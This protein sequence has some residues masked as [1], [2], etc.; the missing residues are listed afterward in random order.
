MRP[1]MSTV[2]GSSIALWS[3]N[4]MYWKIIFVLSLSKLAQPPFLHCIAKIQSR[5][6]CETSIWL[7]SRGMAHAVER[8]QYLRRI[9]HI[10]VKL[11]VKLE[12]PSAGLDIGKTHRP[13]ALVAD[14]LRHQPVRGLHH[15][16]I[17]LRDSSLAQ[18]VDG[19]SGVPHRRDAGLH[20]EG[21][22]WVVRL[23]VRIVDAKLLELVH[24]ANELR[25]VWRVS[26]AGQRDQRV[27]H[28]GID[29][30]ESV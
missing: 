22:S 5:A 3:A 4:G 25:I 17:V 21:G 7:R 27:Q 16:R 26:Q 12:V 28:G 15:A 13:I 29:C 23:A 24:R 2:G 11:I 10:R 18:R 8:Q 30:A 14:L 20:A 6:R 9:I 19:L 1:V